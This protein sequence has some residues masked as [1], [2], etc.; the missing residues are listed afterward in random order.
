L[1]KLGALV[2]AIPIL[3][4]VYLASLLRRGTPARI[5]AGIA[6][7]AIVGIVAVASIPPAQSIA[8]P[9]SSAPPPV[10]AELLDTVRVGHAPSAPFLVRFSVP[11][12]A[13]AVAAALRLQPD[14][15]VTLTWDPTGTALTVAPVGHWQPATLYTIT[16]DTAARAL[17]GGT[18][19][20]PIR[21]VFL[22][23]S[24]GSGDITATDKVGSK[25]RIDT[26]F[27]VALDRPM[28]LEAVKGAV[29]TYPW[30]PGDVTAG[31]VAGQFVFTPA[32][33][34]APA[35]NYRI[36]LEGLVD[37][38]GIAF[39]RSPSME[40]R[41]VGAP[42]VVRFRPRAGTRDVD[43]TAAI[44]VRFTEPMNRAATAAAF[45]VTAGGT[46]VAGTVT[47]AEKDKVLVFD[48]SKDLPYGA[49][50][51]V[52]VDAVAV[53]AAGVPLGRAVNGTF[54]VK[55]KPKPAPAP[56]P[57]PAPAPKPK[58]APKTPTTKP[59]SPSGGGGAV[60]GSWSSVEAYYLKLMNCTRTGGWVTSTG[61][62]SS[63]GGRS[64]AALKLDAGITSRVSRPYA[65]L[66]ATRNLCSHFIG[67]N[68]GNRLRAA[69]YN[70]YR[71]AENIGCLSG[72]PNWVMLSTHLYFQ[73]EKSSN[74]GHYV[75]M[76]NS[77]Y[78]RVGVGVWVSSGRV[79]LVV[80]FYHP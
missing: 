69:G 1:R 54:T 25:A 19:T 51:T 18:L 35:S 44:S 12:D 37:A 50:V 61:A 16:V 49:T 34:L 26:A 13:A 68:P 59:I 7:A 62:C 67:G 27:R 11:M 17:A 21:A 28:S 66:L 5:A 45:R 30:V 15:A 36:W 29:R 6:A 65:K 77:L 33:P 47:W 60:S 24:A 46:A 22:T 70:S 58:P 20:S 72:N 80:D 78:D 14:A 10:A 42:A 40:I 75:N 71:W 38:D 64:V 73:N 53:S 3:G 39:E 63:P 57:K 56:K 32:Q 48:P 76:M 79:R 41:T 4:A 9:V 23:A 55:A 31:D 8:H 43:R 74:G 2:L 52:T